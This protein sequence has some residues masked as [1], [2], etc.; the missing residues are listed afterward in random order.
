VGAA[1]HKVDSDE[2]EG[3]RHQGQHGEPAAASEHAAAG[4]TARRLPRPPLGG[5]LGVARW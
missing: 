2:D 3:G 1:A 5:G 4:G